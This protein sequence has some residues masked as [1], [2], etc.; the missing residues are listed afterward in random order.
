MVIPLGPMGGAAGGLDTPMVPTPA[1]VKERW[2]K[3][4]WV[5][6]SLN[7]FVCV[8]RLLAADVFGALV[9]GL[10]A[11]I[12]YYMVNNDCAN[13]SQYCILLF[14]FLCLINGILDLVNLA[15]NAQGRETRKASPP[16]SQGDLSSG[17][18]S[19]TVVITTT[20]HPFFDPTGGF[21]YNAQSVMMIVSPVAALLGAFLSWLT[22]S[23]F[24]TSL[25]AEPA[26]NGGSQGGFGGYGTAYGGAPGGGGYYSGASG[27]A[28]GPAFT[29]SAGPAGGGRP[30]GSVAA[31]APPRLFEGSGQRLGSG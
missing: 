31:A 28:G 24:T 5:L 25:F 30:L 1:V 11:F 20:K 10:T 8:G 13:M 22:Y 21:L 15:G 4:W 17:S 29:G 14:G 26:E 7:I 18:Q 27:T 12:C 19:T 9:T 16:T 2:S 23:S 6:F 3:W